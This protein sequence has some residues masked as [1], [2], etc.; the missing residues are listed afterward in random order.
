MDCLIS[1]KT[2]LNR[3]NNFEVPSEIEIQLKFIVLLTKVR[4]EVLCSSRFLI[5]EY[6]KTFST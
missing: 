6:F 2:C 4:G 3:L 1:T 5:Y